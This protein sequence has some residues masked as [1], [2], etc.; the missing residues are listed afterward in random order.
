MKAS[1]VPVGARLR[2]RHRNNPR[3]EWQPLSSL[4]DK[5]P[6]REVFVEVVGEDGQGR[7]ERVEFERGAPP[8]NESGRMGGVRE[9]AGRKP[10]QNKEVGEK[11]K[12]ESKIC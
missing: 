5:L 12:K 2:Q 1:D 4:A 9:G 3:G 7:W 10:A 8:G 6:Q 11:R